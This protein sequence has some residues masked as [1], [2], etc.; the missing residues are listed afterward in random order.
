[1]H[2]CARAGRRLLHPLPATPPA[3]PHLLVPLLQASEV[4]RGVLGAALTLRAIDVH[5]LGLLLAP[6]LVAV[7][8][9]GALTAAGALLLGARAAGQAGQIRLRRVRQWRAGQEGC[10]S[11]EQEERHG[12]GV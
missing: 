9:A 7:A 2:G 10:L 1:M 3:G 5:A 4:Q 11:S 8:A 12:V 6:P